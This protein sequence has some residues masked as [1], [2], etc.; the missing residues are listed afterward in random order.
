MGILESSVISFGFWLE[1]DWLD[2]CLCFI[3]FLLSSINDQPHG[4][5]APQ[6]SLRQGDP[7]S[8]FH[9][10]LCTERLIHLLNRENQS[11]QLYGISFSD[12]GPSIKHL[13]L[14]TTIYSC[15]RQIKYKRKNSCESC[16][17][18]A[19]LLV[20]LSTWVNLY[21]IRV[22][23][24]WCNKRNYQQTLQIVNDGG[25]RNYLGLSECCKGYK[26][27][28]LSY[29]FKSLKSRLIRWFARI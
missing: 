4:F 25:I 17:F 18:M 14:L 29:I 12:Y 22:K 8:P 10:V 7:I 9:F 19:N 3:C 16:P 28:M 27:E 15:A 11:H 6:I 20:N 23:S 2:F 13:L 26:F 24:C 1:M 5:I 21:F